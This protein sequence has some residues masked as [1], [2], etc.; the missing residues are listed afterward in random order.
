MWSVGCSEPH[1]QLNAVFETCAELA[2]ALDRLAVLQGENPTAYV[3]ASSDFYD[4]AARQTEAGGIGFV[5]CPSTE[6][7]SEPPETC[8]PYDAAELLGLAEAQAAVLS[9]EEECPT[10]AQRRRGRYANRTA[11]GQAL[12][13]CSTCERWTETLPTT[14]PP[15]PR[16]RKSQ[17]AG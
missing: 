9:A 6:A 12:F 1:D 7:D 17:L 16:L 10:C 4:V 15:G 14:P 5:V 13:I 11:G 2:E 8:Q 3:W